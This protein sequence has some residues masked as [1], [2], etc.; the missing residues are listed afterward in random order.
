M[1]LIKT[2]V[3][4]SAMFA[5][6]ATVA[7]PASA[8]I[9][10]GSH[11]TA[12]GKSVNLSGLEW[13]TWDQTNNFSRTQIENGT[14]NAFIADGWRYANRGEFESLFDSLWG[15]TVEGYDGSNYDGADWLHST[16][17]LTS[18]SNQGVFFGSSLELN[19]GTSFYGDY[20]RTSLGW[21]SFTNA[22]GLSIGLTPLTNIQATI[23]SSVSGDSFSSALVRDVSAVP[24]PPSAI[25]FGTALLG[26]AGLRRRK[27][28]AA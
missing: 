12:G 27:R 17:D 20:T 26:L 25:L 13:L 2:A 15:G 19:S 5:F 23:I 1:N 7:L 21:G 16:M 3:A 9:V 4:A 28:K 8:A 22:Y 11:T 24:L 14:G 6:A 10:S 18:G